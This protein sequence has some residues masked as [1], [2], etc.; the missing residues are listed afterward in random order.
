[1]HT[2][3]YTLPGLPSKCG[4]F[5]RRGP[6]CNWN[7]RNFNTIWT[8]TQMQCTEESEFMFMIFFF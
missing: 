6:F 5:H 7:A 1:M 8:K 2:G 4:I 3:T